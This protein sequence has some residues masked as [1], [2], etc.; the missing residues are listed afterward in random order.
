[1]TDI[2]QAIAAAVGEVNGWDYPTPD[3]IRSV[4]FRTGGA[5]IEVS[6]VQNDDSRYATIASAPVLSA[7]LTKMIDQEQHDDAVS[8]LKASEGMD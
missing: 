3:D 6:Y 2:R 8:K 4:E 5:E 1:M 7:I